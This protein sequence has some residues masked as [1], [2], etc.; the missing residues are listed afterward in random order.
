MAPLAADGAVSGAAG[1]RRSVREGAGP[2]ARVERYAVL[3]WVDRSVTERQAATTPIL[4]AQAAPPTTHP[5][6]TDER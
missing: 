5:P 3:Q 2:R 4:A 1:S 6:I